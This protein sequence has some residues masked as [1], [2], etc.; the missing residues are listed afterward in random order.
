MEKKKIGSNMSERFKDGKTILFSYNTPVALIDK[1]GNA[2]RTEEFWSQT[3]SR[4]INKWLAGQLGKKMPQKF[5]DQFK[6]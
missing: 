2:F 5:F 1:D 3:T 6:L 4:H